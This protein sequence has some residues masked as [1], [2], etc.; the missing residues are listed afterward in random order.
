MANFVR[1]LVGDFAGNVRGELAIMPEEISW[2][3]ND[4]GRVRFRVGRRDEALQKGW[5]NFGNTILLQFENG[6]PVWGGVFDPPRDWDGTTVSVTAYS[7]EYLLSWRSTDKGRYF[8]G[9]SPGAIY[10]ALIAEGNEVE[11]TGIEL[12]AVYT[13]GESH[14]PEYHLAQVLKTIKESVVGRLSDFDFA[15]VPSLDGDRIVFTANFYQRLGT[16]REAALVEDRNL[17]GIKLREQ[18]PI[19][20]DILIA[21]ADTSGEGADGWGEGRI[22]AAASDQASI[23]RWRR[24]QYGEVFGDV[25]IQSTLEGHVARLLA[26]MKE[27]HN[28]W[29]MEADDRLPARF[30]DYGLGD[31]VRLQAPS[32]GVGGTNTRVRLLGR[33]YRP[34]KGVCGLVVR[35]GGLED[36]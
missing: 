15:V 31:V 28:L 33:D 5:L 17:T 14:Y 16:V 21:G 35:E 32:Y 19:R 2:V 29:S 36:A 6:L 3:L 34:G 26:E 13:G 1:A 10:S 24:R 12:G 25:S 27:P 9:S 4:V 18:G 22:T 11:A 20:N 8:S 7:G 23:N 30:R